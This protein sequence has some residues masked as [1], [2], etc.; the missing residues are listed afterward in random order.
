M[1][2]KKFIVEIG[3]NYLGRLDAKQVEDIIN[4]GSPLENFGRLK[5]LDVKEMAEEEE[6]E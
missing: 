1:E 4:K 6:N 3:D 2:Y 5:Y